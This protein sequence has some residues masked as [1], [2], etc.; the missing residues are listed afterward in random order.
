MVLKGQCLWYYLP[1]PS[2][3]SLKA[4]VQEWQVSLWPERGHHASGEMSS[5]LV[6]PLGQLIQSKL[7]A[8]ALAGEGW[9]MDPGEKW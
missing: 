5:A 2:L 4:R 6:S 9:K 3:H 1:H 8:T 7:G